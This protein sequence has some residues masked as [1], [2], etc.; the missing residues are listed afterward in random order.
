MRSSS[1]ITIEHRNPYIASWSH[2]MAVVPDRWALLRIRFEGP[3]A[4]CR[5]RDSRGRRLTAHVEWLPG[6]AQSGERFSGLIEH[7]RAL[8]ADLPLWRQGVH[9]TGP[10][11]LALFVDYPPFLR[12]DAEWTAWNARLIDELRNALQA[13]RVQPVTFAGS[14]ERRR[15]AFSLPFDIVSHGAAAH[16]EL[17]ALRARTWMQSDDVKKWGVTLA[18]VSATEA[19][20]L[21]A[22]LREQNRDI[23]ITDHP[24]I[25]F[26]V[27]RDLRLDARPRLIIVMRKAGEQPDLPP[28]GTAAVWFDP[29]FP[30]LRVSELLFGFA[31]DLP[32]HEA[33]RATQRRGGEA[34][35][36]RVFA[37]PWTNQ[38]LRIRDALVQMQ[39]EAERLELRMPQANLAEF[40]DRVEAKS[41]DAAQS[42]ALTELRNSI[43]PKPGVAFAVEDEEE[44]MPPWKV[45]GPPPD[46][47]DSFV[48]A[49]RA[50]TDLAHV[51]QI[52]GSVRSIPQA[53]ENFEQ[54]SEG[55]VPMA[56]RSAQ[57]INAVRSA[58]D[59]ASRVSPLVTNPSL[60]AI[61]EQHQQRTVDIALQRLET[62][63]LLAS[64]EPRTRLAAGTLYRLRVHVGN[65]M[66]DSLIVGE[67]PPIDVLLPDTTDERGHLLDV[68]VQGKQFRVESD[69]TQQLRV[70]PLGGSEPVYFAVRAP[71]TSGPASLRVHLYYRNHLVQSYLLDAEISANGE[72]AANE[73]VLKVTLAY[74]RVRKLEDAENLQPRAL[75]IAMNDSGR[76]S[77]ELILKGDDEVSA[78]FELKESAFDTE[79]QKFRR[80]L[81]TAARD[82]A[83]PGNGR[84]Y[85][86]IAAGAA[87][88]VDVANTVRAFARQGYNLYEAMVA[89]VPQRNTKMRQQL[90]DLA[91]DHD[92]KIQVVRMSPNDTFPWNLIYD[93]DLPTPR[94]GAPES[95]VCLGTVI[96]A[97][98]APVPCGHTSSTS[99]ICINGFWSIR[100]YLEELIGE[101][102][103][104]D[105]NVTR[106]AQDAVR[107]VCDAALPGAGDFQTDMEAVI[108][109]PHLAFGP[110]V[111]TTLLDLLW[112]NPPERPSI[113]IVVGHLEQ[114]T[115]QGEPDTP[116]VVLVKAS[117]WL[118]RAELGKRATKALGWTQPRPIV[119]L[120]ACESFDLDATTINNFIT[121]LSHAG[122]GAI[123]GAEA[124]IPASL[125]MRCAQL[126][127]SALWDNLTLG[128]AMTTFRRLVLSEGNPLAFV[129]SGI[130]SVDLKLN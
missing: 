125:A 9:S 68:V 63:P 67:R 74:T 20:A 32:I 7:C 18:D 26:A 116:R 80:T 11:P 16:T 56:G 50:Y 60:R 49:G 121:T 114:R 29:M 62:S 53:F 128:E 4:V 71:E 110:T 96:D 51:R 21:E 61:L 78:E 117:E 35:G 111:E 104:P 55:L 119:M 10:V 84:V 87:P 122:A 106:P 69:A 124:V 59:A 105:P 46:Q 88:S 113:L 112:K 118:T 66:P 115:I 101:G 41:K 40:F 73:P 45:G 83:N 17:E 8:A 76:A 3:Y 23:L 82:P 91:Q 72:T 57:L 58:A 81:D 2:I 22:A 65:P 79:V 15:P 42:V 129:F 102:S 27:C 103:D 99:S 54:E 95:P 30:Q 123:I 130:G 70:P 120:M 98:G 19:P 97:S 85:P 28:S 44:A 77:H 107:V 38:S 48:R 39:T 25:A 89:R 64:L 86:Q 47:D 5:L 24:E 126:M 90:I 31:H 109:A 1:S 52:A 75:S 12:G 43:E 14:L 93:F 108:A 6:W 36:I 33:V 100:H 127:T 92:K 37:D 13:D 34:P 94:A